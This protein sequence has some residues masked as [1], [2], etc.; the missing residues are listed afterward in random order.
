M[1]TT[2]LTDHEIQREAEQKP[3]GR[4]QEGDNTFDATD[5]DLL[6]L[7]KRI[8]RN[9]LANVSAVWAQGQYLN[10]YDET[11]TTGVYNVRFRLR[12]DHWDTT[13]TRTF[14]LHAY[15]QNVDCRVRISTTTLATATGGT[16]AAWSSSSTFTL[17]ASG[18]QNYTIEFSPNGGGATETWWAWMIE[19][20]PSATSGDLDS[21]Y[22]TNLSRRL[23]DTAFDA[24]RSLSLFQMSALHNNVRQ[25]SVPSSPSIAHCYP[26]D[27]PVRLSSVA[28]RAH[29][30]YTIQA[31]PWVDT[32]D[33]TVYVR[34]DPNDITKRENVDVFAF[35]EG[36]DLSDAIDRATTVST[37]SLTGLNFADLPITRRNANGWSEVR[38]YLGFIS[39]VGAQLQTGIVLELINEGQYDKDDALTG[40]TPPHAHGRALLVAGY[41][42]SI[43]GGIKGSGAAGADRENFADVA[44]V[45]DST[46][47]GSPVWLSPNTWKQPLA[48]VQASTAVAEL[49]E[50]GSLDLYSIQIRCNSARSS[51]LKTSVATTPPSGSLI[52]SIQEQCNE[53]SK[54]GTYMAGAIQHG[55]RLQLSDGTIWGNW[56]PIYPSASWSAVATYPIPSLP[57]PSSPGS[58]SVYPASFFARV[59]YVVLNQ[60]GPA[61]IDTADIDWRLVLTSDVTSAPTSDILEAGDTVGVSAPI[62]KYNDIRPSWTLWDMMKASENKYA[63]DGTDAYIMTYTQQYCWPSEAIQGLPVLATDVLAV[64]VHTTGGNYPLWAEVQCDVPNSPGTYDV[65]VVGCSVWCGPRV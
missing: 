55:G 60:G 10:G 25:A 1:A 31:P 50:V 46:A 29:G 57:Q 7:S 42:A 61:G 14:K 38:V 9:T 54:Y 13:Q 43:N 28:R 51:D 32:L 17:T 59:Y 26:I 44:V 52:R 30:P 20:V 53:L 35:V 16:S 49:R 58:A 2:L 6:S 56:M 8:D 18:A 65:L 47:A 21:F 19:E 37:T 15:A 36:E 33:V 5:H 34:Q 11:G 62:Y 45:E 63:Y 4:I 48:W 64:D 23:D 40:T 41:D 3:G 12:A 27:Y 39:D 24:D 22:S